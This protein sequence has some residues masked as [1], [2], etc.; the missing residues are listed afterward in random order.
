LP[1]PDIGETLTQ[2]GLLSTDQLSPA[3]A[4]KTKV[5]EYDAFNVLNRCLLIEKS[6]YADILLNSFHRLA[7]L[8]VATEASGTSNVKLSF[9]TPLK[10]V[11]ETVG[12]VLASHFI[13]LRL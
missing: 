4:R 6:L 2:D 10:A 12:G 9:A 5:F 8:Y 11:D 7:F 13:E 3:G 1:V